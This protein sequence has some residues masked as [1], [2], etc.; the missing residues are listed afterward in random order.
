MSAF[1]VP[2]LTVPVDC[3]AMGDALAASEALLV[4]GDRT[5]VIIAVNPEKVV[6]SRENAALAAALGQSDLLIPDGI[7]VV[8]AA[9]LLHGRA[10]SRVAG[11]D[12]MH[13]LCVT[14]A[15]L[16]KSVF[17]LGG[18]PGVASTAA[19]RLAE[20]I[21]GL[22]VAGARDGYFTQEQT[23]EVIDEVNASGAEVL[24][25]GFGSP[26]Q[27][28]W[29]TSHRDRLRVKIC[30]CVGGSI[31]VMA[32]RVKRAPQR[33]QRM[34]LEWFYRL[35]SEPSRLLRQKRLPVFVL[36]VAREFFTTGRLRRN[37]P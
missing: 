4:N 23:D 29:V 8:L 10:I 17:I 16:G 34:N 24:F 35:C 3:V 37:A 33:F 12:L 28:I 2:I 15:K 13:M 36:G 27:E 7:G 20:S 21:P 1:R 5:A 18:G 11:V 9:R 30:Q 14:A 31:D 26:K 6:A 22:R 32:G 25:V 19:Q